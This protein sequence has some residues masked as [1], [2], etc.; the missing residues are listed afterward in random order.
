MFT[1]STESKFEADAA[2][3]I[4]YDRDSKQFV[5]LFGNW[6][7]DSVMDPNKIGSYPH[8]GFICDHEFELLRK[9]KLPIAKEDNDVSFFVEG[10]KVSMKESVM[11]SPRTSFSEGIYNRK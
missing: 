8:D 3:L 4:F 1:D 5:R 9:E 6:M 11:C 7:P 2:M 10:N